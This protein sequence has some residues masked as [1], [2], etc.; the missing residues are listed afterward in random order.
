MSK[1][2]K[3]AP[4]PGKRPARSVRTSPTPPANALQDRRDRYGNRATHALLSAIFGE[5]LAG[6]MVQVDTAPDDGHGGF[7]TPP[8][9]LGNHNPGSVDV[10]VEMQVDVPSL[11]DP[12]RRR[13][14][15]VELLSFYMPTELVQKYLFY[16]VPATHVFPT[17]E[18]ALAS[19][20]RPPVHAQL[21]P[22]ITPP[23]ET[24]STRANTPTP[25]PALAVT[26]PAATGG[27]VTAAAVGATVYT[28]DGQAHIV[29][30]ATAEA[31]VTA[32][33]T[34]YA[35][36]AGSTSLLDAGGHF[37]IID[38]GTFGP[39][40][41]AVADA[42]LRALEAHI[43]RGGVIAQILITHAHADH[44]DLLPELAARFRIGAI[45][46]NQL[47]A[48]RPSFQRIMD[49]VR[50]AHRAR[51]N[52]EADRVRA[53]MVNERPA[54]ETADRGDPLTRSQ[55]WN[56][57][58]DQRMRAAL[59][60][61]PDIMLE[62]LVPGV[63]GRLAI[64][65]IPIDGTPF[66]PQ[67]VGTPTEDL[68]PGVR[69]PAV[70]DPKF[71]D[72]LD[73]RA[74][75]GPTSDKLDRFSSSWVVDVKGQTRFMV[76][77]DIRAADFSN[78]LHD[79]RR[80]V[81]SL[82]MEARFQVWDA[83]HHMQI[84]WSGGGAAA[85]GSPSVRATQLGQISRF[86]D[87][88]RAGTSGA[89]GT[90]IVVVSAFEGFGTHGTSF[91]DPAHV[92][93][94][95][96]LGFHVFLAT[97]GRDVQ[98]LE[99]VTSQ[100]R[101]VTGVVG[102]E[103]GGLRPREQLMRRTEAALAELRDTARLSR[104]ELQRARAPADRAAAQTRLTQANERIS[105]ID[106]LRLE[107]LDAIHQE[108]GR[109]VRGNAPGTTTPRPAVAPA[110]GAPE[111]AQARALALDQTLT[112]EGF[113]R[114]VPTSGSP[115][116]SEAALAIV[117]PGLLDPNAP[118][119]SAGAL[120]LELA[121][122]RERIRE[123]E[124]RPPDTLDAARN[125]AELLAEMHRY[126]IALEAQVRLP[127]TTGSSR[128]VL[129]DELKTA[130][131]RIA[132]LTPGPETRTVRERI[133]GTGA[134][135]ETQIVAPRRFTPD[136]SA[137]SAVSVSPGAVNEAAPPE[138]PGLGDRAGAAIEGVTTPGFGALMI[139]Q[140][141]TAETD[142]LARAQAG[143]A[144]GAEVAAT[145]THSALG[146]TVGYRMLRGVPVSNG[147]FA[148]LSLL[149]V[150][151]AASRD[152][153]T[154]DQR[155]TAIAYAALR[156]GVNLGLMAA[157]GVLMAVVPPP[158]GIL[159][160]LGIMMLGDRILDALGAH[161]W[162][163]RL[164]SFQPRQVIAVEQK[165]RGLIDEYAVI[166]GAIELSE[167]DNASLRQVGAPDPVATREAARRLADQHR[168][169]AI[170]LEQNILSAFSDAYDRAQGAY[171]GLAELDDMRR[172]FYELM[173]RAHPHNE[174]FTAYRRERAALL[175][176]YE[177][178]EDDFDESGF[179]ITKR[180][181]RRVR[182]VTD[183]ERLLLAP[184]RAPILDQARTAFE[185]IERS[186]SLTTATASDIMSMEQWDKIDRKLDEM[187]NRLEQ[188]YFA[189]GNEPYGA[190]IEMESEA[191]RMLDNARYRVQPPPGAY[192]TEA[193]L[194]ATAPGYPTYMLMLDQRE[195]R[196]W[197]TQ[198]HLS[199]MNAGRTPR[200]RWDGTPAVTAAERESL[201]SLSQGRNADLNLL[202][203]EAALRTY[204]ALLRSVPTPPS[205]LVQAMFTNSADAGSA[206]AEYLNHHH[207]YRDGLRRI[208]LQQTV[209]MA[210]TERAQ[211]VV[212]PGNTIDLNGP[213]PPEPGPG[214]WRTPA[215]DRDRLQRLILNVRSIVIRRHDELG[216]VFPSE[217]A[218]LVSRVRESELAQ[219]NVAM[220]A[221]P[222]VTPLSAAEQRAA[223]ESLIRDTAPQLGSTADR[224]AQ[225]PE[226]RRS[227][228]GGL[229]T[230][231][232][233]LGGELQGYELPHELEELNVTAS[234]N[235]I[236]GDLGP[237]ESYDTGHR[238][239]RHTHLTRRVIPLNAAA[240]EVLRGTAVRQ[241]DARCL[242]QITM[243]D[244]HP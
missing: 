161:D 120:A 170:P 37:I 183:D 11:A 142:V 99:V 96:S 19:H 152:Y 157:G 23:T 145:S 129:D 237:G 4:A 210:M 82:G 9:L 147:V 137:T 169:R 221:S 167:R 196:L 12:S 86:L 42:T 90:D 128:Q 77:P 44:M 212:D 112:A 13:A 61:I 119:G 110:E 153:A 200:P 64:T 243:G 85:P 225:I 6:Q 224:L 193:M 114:P 80:A 31:I 68:A 192:R 218:A 1:E 174:E 126:R 60:A 109:N 171:A 127:D 138:R 242:H 15:D 105:R 205:E 29:V 89:P 33:F 97:A 32:T 182:Q 139:Y 202:T 115:R 204:Q 14:R 228:R 7:I 231:I 156:G 121:Q 189:Q 103:R 141:F 125:R 46:I 155:D 94:L 21:S 3:V 113:N 49:R 123:I 65:S 208:E 76:L 34:R 188:A 87:T 209:L 140:T 226:L 106:R 52:A 185:G 146:V 172:R 101:R 55:R 50:Q 95:K 238:H 148:V 91:V 108:L 134:L 132:E 73:E 8:E 160:G 71:E 41:S 180:N 62:R 179:I 133:P 158:L 79:F 163:E 197:W 178:T 207:D 195:Q 219:L 216:M 22:P 222:L 177:L 162:I 47:Q 84:G 164:T 81:K 241:V 215:P 232:Y 35:V 159:A 67:T 58:R 194:P 186:L 56:E 118:P 83:G 18:A 17:R 51:V 165:M 66:Q 176:R 175:A 2:K 143:T 199:D 75:R 63:R 131:Q 10:P 184:V 149:E 220:G 136:A 229:L 5:S 57:F 36:G 93:L 144:S 235:V 48:D 187:N 26:T 173:Q 135:M 107:Y 70:V 24:T 59:D 124:G 72:E 54:W 233:R 39:A 111:P 191:R 30:G 69:A 151:Q 92:W 100:N 214:S 98:V 234:Q 211:R 20:L 16:A 27:G 201:P 43:G 181:R 213:L 168:I 198:H 244:L 116:F 236:I 102:E 223:R 130:R 227:G 88:F 28:P 117:R 53:E 206:Y 104:A 38:A 40:G 166:V 239:L 217:S 150:A 230:G 122:A 203:A 74:G 78:I 240:I 25:A 154:P 45:R 190:F